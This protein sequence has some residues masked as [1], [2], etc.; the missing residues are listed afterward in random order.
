MSVVVST[1]G[2][3][4]HASFLI[5]G[6][7]WVRIILSMVLFGLVGLFASAWV[8]AYL[9]SRS[10][11]YVSFMSPLCGLLGMLFGA[12]L[13]VKRKARWP[14]PPL[15]FGRRLER[16]KNPLV[17]L[18]VPAALLI[19][20]IL[21]LALAN[22]VDSVCQQLFHTDLVTYIAVGYALP[23]S[24]VIGSLFAC[25]FAISYLP[26][27]LLL[28]L[29]FWRRVREL[30][31]FC[32]GCGYNLTGNITGCCPE[33]GRSFDFGRLLS[34]PNAQDILTGFN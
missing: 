1:F 24:L 10:G 8:I 4:K 18:G 5:Q 13:T 6:M 7:R 26:V 15:R 28:R 31:P 34:A 29:C 14:D 23:E 32:G 16:R 20:P 19:F 21:F 11:P 2:N 25:I 22:L 12:A 27:R 17:W 9:F 30:T 33:C 3:H